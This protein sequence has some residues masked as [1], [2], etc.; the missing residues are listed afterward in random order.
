MS[1]GPRTYEDQGDARERAGECGVVVN[2]AGLAR[3]GVNRVVDHQ[4]VGT[5][6]DRRAAQLDGAFQAVADPRDHT[7]SSAAHADMRPNDLRDL[8]VR[9]GG[10]LAGVPA[11]D[12]QPHSAPNQT[13][14]VSL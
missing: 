11:G 4:S 13:V 12:Q 10:E 1:C 14:Q 7:R 8:I 3:V 5:S 2:E 9:E 6:R